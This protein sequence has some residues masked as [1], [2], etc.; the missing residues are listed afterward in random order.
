MPSLAPKPC[1][2]PGC[3]ALVR[4]GGGYCPA[5]KRV[6]P[7]SFSDRSR[8]SRHERGY[9]TQW[10]KIRPR[11]IKRDGNL[12]R[13]CRR[14]GRFTA[15]GDK[16]FSAFVDHIT[17]K[18]L[19]RQKGWTAEQIDADENLETLCRTCHRQKTDKEKNF[20]RLSVKN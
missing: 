5:H 10:D 19:A 9:G 13:E 20:V 18:F 7:G 15:V 3:G 11:I 16:P 1:R 14:Q 17:P 2:S 12:C 8:G 6:S 4:G